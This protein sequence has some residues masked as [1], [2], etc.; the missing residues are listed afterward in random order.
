MIDYEHMQGSFPM[1]KVKYVF[2]RNWSIFLGW[3]MVEVVHKVLLEATK[4][5]FAYVN[6]IDVSADEATTT[7][8]T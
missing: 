3:G 5:T 8:N 1:L 2:K 6:F 4:A 7:N